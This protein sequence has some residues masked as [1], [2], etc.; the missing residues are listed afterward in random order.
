MPIFRYRLILSLFR[1]KLISRGLLF[2]LIHL[3]F[4]L[5]SYILSRVGVTIDGVGLIIKFID[6]LQIVTTSNYSAIANSRIL[7]F[8]TAHNNSSEAAVSSP[9]DVPLIPGS[10]SRKLAAIYHQIRTL[11]TVVSRLFSRPVQ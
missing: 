4:I 7:Q 2:S 5:L 3:P 6:H 10:R 11:L 9:A 1:H 8:T